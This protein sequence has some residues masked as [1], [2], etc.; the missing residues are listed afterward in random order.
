MRMDTML[1]K[2]TSIQYKTK[3]FGLKQKVNEPAILNYTNENIWI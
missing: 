1:K 2:I 3:L